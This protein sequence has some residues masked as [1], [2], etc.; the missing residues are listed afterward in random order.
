MLFCVC[1]RAVFGAFDSGLE[2]PE[3]GVV[4]QAPP[5]A[6][7]P[8]PAPPA[9]AKP[10][11]TF[12]CLKRCVYVLCVSVCVGVAKG[13]GCLRAWCVCVCECARAV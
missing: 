3:G 2:L 1:L 6:P 13:E 11:G 10:A 8:A 7:A 9:E 4:R 12:L 5:P